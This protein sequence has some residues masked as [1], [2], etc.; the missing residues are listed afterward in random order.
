MTIICSTQ[1]E[2]I[3]TI[4]GLVVKGLTFDADAQTLKI[5]LTGG[6]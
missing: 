6:Y 2:F 4:A 5:V 3:D 1:V